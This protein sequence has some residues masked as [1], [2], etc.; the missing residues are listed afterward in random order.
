MER[1]LYK[2][3]SAF[4]RVFVRL[5][6]SMQRLDASPCAQPF[7]CRVL[8]GT[9]KLPVPTRRYAVRAVGR[10]LRALRVSNWGRSLIWVHQNPEVSKVSQA[11]G[12]SN[13]RRLKIFTMLHRSLARALQLHVPAALTRAARA[14]C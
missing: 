10:A 12:V 6:L 8:V 2:S 5:V 11:V 9:T 7:A 1:T 13:A 4:C 14:P 3:M